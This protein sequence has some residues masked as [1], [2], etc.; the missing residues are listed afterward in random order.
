MI[1]Q[2]GLFSVKHWI[3]TV[4]RLLLL[5]LPKFSTKC[6]ETNQ[7]K[8]LALSAMRKL[9]FLGSLLKAF[10]IQSTF[11]YKSYLRHKF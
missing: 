5:I 1:K 10:L 6:G 8:N 2:Y 11:F 3:T 7:A 9:G 4:K